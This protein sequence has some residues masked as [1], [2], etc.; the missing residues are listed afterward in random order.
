MAEKKEM[1]NENIKKAN[2]ILRD[3]KL[4]ELLKLTSGAESDAKKIKSSLEEKLKALEVA[5]KE[6]ALKVETAV[7][8]EAQTEEVPAPEK[9]P[10]K[11]PE[12]VKETHK[13]NSLESEGQLD[14]FS[15]LG[16]DFAA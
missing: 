4:E 16:G 11:K 5:R 7:E 15:M 8:K 10:E 13:S 3:G 1:R 2:E 6:E 14:L 12:P 9:T